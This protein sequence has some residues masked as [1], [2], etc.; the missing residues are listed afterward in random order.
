[1]MLFDDAERAPVVAGEVDVAPLVAA[2]PRGAAALP[3]YTFAAGVFRE[4][5]VALQQPLIDAEIVAVVPVISPR[6]RWG[7]AFVTSGAFGAAFTEEDI[8]AV[9]SLSDQCALLFD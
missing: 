4:L 5:P 7:Y 8:V 2:W 6:R 9:Q 3:S 1:A